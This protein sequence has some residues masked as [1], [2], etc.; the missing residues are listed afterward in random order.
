[1]D[2]G[3][4]AV[5]LRI[6]GPWGCMHCSCM[7][8]CRLRAGFILVSD[9]ALREG[10]RAGDTTANLLYRLLHGNGPAGLGSV[11]VMLELIGGPSPA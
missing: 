7:D 11:T 4:R 5:Q 10:L 1:M 3:A 9:R 6:W 2:R 8:V